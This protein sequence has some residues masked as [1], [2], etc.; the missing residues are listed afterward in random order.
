[1]APSFLSPTRYVPLYGSDDVSSHFKR[2]RQLSASIIYGLLFRLSWFKGTPVY[3]HIIFDKAG[4]DKAAYDNSDV[5][6]QELKRKNHCAQHYSH[7]LNHKNALL[8]KVKVSIL[9]Y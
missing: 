7:L 3:T 8:Y 1:M 2:I 9:F 4:Y 5:N 6:L